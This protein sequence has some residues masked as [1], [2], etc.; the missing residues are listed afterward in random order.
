[1]T[2]SINRILVPVDFSGPSE[3]AVRYATTV[4]NRFGARLKLLHVVEDPFVTGA[5]SA[6]AF[7]PNTTELLDTL[8]NAA[9]QQM[10]DLKKR[11]AAHGFV[12]ETAVI[13]GLPAQTIVEEAQ[14]GRFDLIVLGTHGRAGL[15][16]VVMGSIAER[17]VQKAPCAVLTVRGA[18]QRKAAA[19]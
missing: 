13:T 10:A 1:M 8:I 14:T 7:V 6:E 18:G 9:Q 11:L 2:E 4:A 12:V 15:S 17:V 3:E 5:W 16:H 19:A